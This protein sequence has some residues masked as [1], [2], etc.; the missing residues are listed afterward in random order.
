MSKNAWRAVAIVA[1]V[2]LLVVVIGA[3]LVGGTIN[4]CRGTGIMWNPVPIAWPMM[5][6]MML[7]PIGLLLLGAIGVF[8]LVQTKG[9]SESKE[10]ESALEIPKLRLAKG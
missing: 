1:I 5:S 3:S 2:L 10:P 8:W 6:F 9:S 4:W 7:I